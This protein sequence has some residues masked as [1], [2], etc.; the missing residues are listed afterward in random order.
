M[1]CWWAYLLSV[2]V[3]GCGDSGGTD[4]GDGVRRSD[5]A[6]IADAAVVTSDGSIADAFLVDAAF[7]ADAAI[8]DAAVVDAPPLGNS[9]ALAQPDAPPLGDAGA[10]SYD[11]VAVVSGSG[12]D[13][14]KGIDVDADDHVFV[15]GNVTGMGASVFGQTVDVGGDSDVFVAKLRADD[16]QPDW[17]AT[18]GGS[19]ADSG[20]GI[21]VDATGNAIVVGSFEA[22]VDFGDGVE[23]TSAGGADLFVIKYDSS[24]DISW[25]RVVGKGG[26]DVALGVAVDSNN[27]V[28]VTGRYV[29]GVD[30]GNGGLPFAGGADAFVAK[31]DGSSGATLWSRGLGGDFFE[32]GER[33][34]FDGNDNLVVA[35]MIQ[36]DTDFGSGDAI[37]MTGVGTDVFLARYSPQ[38]VYQWARTYGSSGSDRAE[39]M[40]IDGADIFLAGSFVGTIDFSGRV[41]TAVEEHADAFWA[42]F[43]VGS[44]IAEAAYRYGGVSFDSFRAIDVDS[45]HPV[46]GGDFSV[47]GDFGTGTVMSSGGSDLVVAKYAGDTGESHWL[48]AFGDIGTDSVHAIA[49]DS[50]ANVVYGAEVSGTVSIGAVT[51]TA[52]GGDAVIV[53]RSP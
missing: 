2:A 37:E 52:I 6:I 36:S 29:D 14:V 16:G 20:E 5:A 4:F 24:G 17:Q 13:R 48:E 43:D 33:V 23:R 21:A 44:G 28:A 25:I 41:L 47:A 49:L 45:G 1:K 35:G 30:F 27:D 15:V 3:V 19:G 7:A 12:H 11:W 32:R 40:V 26:R 22:T 31:L 50:M 38:G 53:K 9:D 42:R 39:A 46:V 51:F 18:F 8:P 10:V 34:A